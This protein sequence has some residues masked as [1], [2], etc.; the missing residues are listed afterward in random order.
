MREA[1]F[2]VKAKTLPFDP[3]PA[4]WNAILPARRCGP[5]CEGQGTADVVIVGAGFAGL[6]A[7]LRLKQ[8]EPGIR[9]ALLEARDI[10]EGPAGRNSG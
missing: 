1:E 9:V 2:A 3:G 7:A 5:T 6:T 4:A 10:A 8:L